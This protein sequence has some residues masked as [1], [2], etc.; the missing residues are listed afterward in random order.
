MPTRTARARWEGTVKEGK[1]TVA[2]GSGAFEG[3]Y[4]FQSRFEDGLG[5][6]PEELVAA[7][8][9]GCF[10]MALSLALTE[11]GYQPRSIETTADATIERVEG[12]FTITSVRLQTQADVPGLGDTEFQEKADGAKQNCPVSRALAGTDI[13]LDA[14]LTG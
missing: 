10:S 9:A 12:S 3:P 7:A 14:R 5:T 2:L 4:S 13:R 1:G 6:N 11:A 8:E